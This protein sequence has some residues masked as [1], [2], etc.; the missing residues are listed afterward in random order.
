M[1]S[2]VQGQFTK[3]PG[4]AGAGGRSTSRLATR[5]G[6]PAAPGFSE[7]APL[8]GERSSRPSESGT[9]SRDLAAKV[10]QRHF[11]QDSR[12]AWG[13]GAR[14]SHCRGARG[15]G[16]SLRPRQKLAVGRSRDDQSSFALS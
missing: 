16:W 2:D 12:S 14:R 15:M 11:P 9:A 6:L 8:S 5:T 10:N 3:K 7:R 13:W 1:P 4:S